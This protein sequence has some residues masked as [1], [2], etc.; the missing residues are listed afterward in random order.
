M[1]LRNLY[2]I[3]FEKQRKKRKELVPE[4]VEKQLRNIETS[5]SG[6]KEEDKVQPEET[7]VKDEL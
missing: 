5:T 2:I 7:I 4:F 1:Y 3:I 6:T